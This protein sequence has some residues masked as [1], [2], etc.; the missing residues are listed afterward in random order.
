MRRIALSLIA[1]FFLS[2]CFVLDELEQGRDLIDSH[3]PVAR[4]LDGNEE[5]NEDSADSSG[6]SIQSFSEAKEK[7]QQWW[8]A[9]LE[10]DPV[11]VDDSD[12]V[13]SCVIG[14]QLVFIRTSDC[15]TRGGHAKKRRSN[16]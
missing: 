6:F 1:A 7:M 12:I 15:A 16:L 5:T 4:E 13:I 3:S 10:E 2:G 14:D 9:A 11:R 8:Q